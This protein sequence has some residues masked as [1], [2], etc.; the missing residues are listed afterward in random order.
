VTDAELWWESL[1]LVLMLLGGVT[2]TLMSVLAARWKARRWMELVGLLAVV[3]VITGAV[4]LAIV[5]VVTW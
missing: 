1:S 3:A 5:T 4:I 2:F